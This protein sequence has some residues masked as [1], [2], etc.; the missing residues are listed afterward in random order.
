MTLRSRLPRS[1]PLRSLCL[2]V[3]LTLFA[4][5]GCSAYRHMLKKDKNANEGV[6]VE[7]LYAKGHRSM[8]GSNWANAIT[9][10]KRLIAQYPFGPYT[11][12]A[13]METAYAQYKSG[14]NDDAI[15][16]IDR[17]IRT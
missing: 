7:Q 5:S 2:L 17:F 10:Y 16:T 6:P 11:E 15:S 13:L 1:L 3:L 14:S 9:V 8:T 4:L 12:Q